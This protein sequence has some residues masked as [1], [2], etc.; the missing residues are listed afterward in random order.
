MVWP[1][2]SCDLNI[3]ESDCS[4]NPPTPATSLIFLE[5]AVCQVLKKK[6]T[7]NLYSGEV[8]VF[9]KTPSDED[10]TLLTCPYVIFYVLQYA[11]YSFK[12][13]FS[14][15][16]TCDLDYFIIDQ[17]QISQ[18]SPLTHVVFSRFCI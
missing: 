5:Q 18:S 9:F 14:L 6:Q 10:L 1:T 7:V 17:P 13:R 8:E 16:G 11:S 4:L 2:Q 12:T 15:K 3:I